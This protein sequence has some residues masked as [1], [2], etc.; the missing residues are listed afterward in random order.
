MIKTFYGVILSHNI[1]TN[2]SDKLVVVSGGSRGIGKAIVQKYIAEGYAVA[3][4]GKSMANLETLKSEISSE[5]LH[6]FKADVSIK[7][8]VR[9]FSAFVTG[10]GMPMVALVHNAGVFVQSP[11]MDEPEDTLLSQL[12]TNL[13]SAYYLT[14][15]LNQ[16]IEKGCHIF[17]ICSIASLAGYAESGSYATSKFAMLGF[18]KS[19]RQELIP[20]G[21]KVTAVLPGATETDSWA[22]SGLAS[23]RFI[24]SEDVAD[25]VFATFKL[26]PSAL[27]E[28][29][30]IRPSMGDI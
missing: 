2:M 17:S 16:K 3:T 29:L 6:V 12:N 1:K 28:E 19:L 10:L 18:T 13:L 23:E 30:L 15:F 7:E 22:G 21:A 4:C 26:S 14:K 11:M 5:K 27:V 24:K 20:R 25:M 8:E 9:A